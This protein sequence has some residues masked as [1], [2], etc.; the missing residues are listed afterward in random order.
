V[1]IYEA[2]QVVEGVIC[3]LFSLIFMVK[4]FVLVLG[5][6]CADPLAPKNSSNAAASCEVSAFFTICI[7]FKT[8]PSLPSLHPESIDQTLNPAL[9]EP[10][11]PRGKHLQERP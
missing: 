1:F 11:L 10:L 5:I 8:T 9:V 3:E 6:R 4:V 2:S 7:K